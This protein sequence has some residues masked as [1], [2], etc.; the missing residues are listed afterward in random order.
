MPK[1]L[2]RFST[3]LALLLILYGARGAHL[4]SQVIS[5]D[6][7]RWGSRPYIPQSANAIHVQ[8]NIVQVPVV[9]RD[10]HGKAVAGLKKSD[11]QLFD[12]GHA[13]EIAS[14]TVGNLAP[15]PVQYVQS[16]QIVDASLP[17]VAPPV[18][19]SSPPAPRYVALFFDDLTMRTPELVMARKAAESF[20]TTNLK[21]GDRIGIF[22]TSTQDTLNFTDN[23]PDL[24]A[25]LGRL[26]SHRRI[27]GDGTCPMSPYQASLITKTFD[28]HSDALDL[29][30]RLTGCGR[31]VQ[32]L[33]NTAREMVGQ[34][35]QLAQQTMG[36]IDDVI[37]YLGRMPGHRMLVLASSG[38]LTETLQAKQDALINEALSANVIINSID[39]KG[40][41]AEIPGYDEDNQPIKLPPGKWLALFDEFK[42]ANREIQNDPLAILAEGTGGHFYHNRND[43]D[44]GLKDMAAAPDISYVLTFSPGDLKRNGAAHSLKVKLADSHG[45][46]ISARRG[47]LAPNATLS[48]SEKKKRNLDSAVTTSEIQTAIRTELTT[49]IGKN[50][51]GDPVLKV[52]I[53]V[54]SSR[55]PYQTQGDRKVERLIFITALFDEHDKFLT[56]VQ[57][58]MDLRLKLETVES[59]SDQGLDAKLSIQAAAGN[60]RLRQV[61]QEVGDGR[62]TTINRNVTIQ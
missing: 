19:P 9:V 61:V 26:V 60:Y 55:L 44:V 25:T 6:E 46:T 27:A 37:H 38:F 24:L 3:L 29:G 12:D 28:T 7:I 18:N 48:D 10:S 13:V 5:E 34:A 59:L 51:A 1:P 16:P 14:F 20:V 57:G 50:G 45:M 4:H 11:F 31:D 43:L 42:T 8:T 17:P 49:D 21:P 22:T 30:M 15:Q 52:A 41:V 58:V 62:I 39:A 23:V 54:D 2:A 33:T 56:G 40:L 53:H 35:E 36:I 32:A 47:Y